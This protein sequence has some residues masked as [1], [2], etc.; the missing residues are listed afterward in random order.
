MRRLE[1]QNYNT[2]EYYNKVFTEHFEESGLDTTDLWRTQWLLGR[3]KGGRLLDI[4]CGISPLPLFASQKEGSE[5]F[6]LDFADEIISKFKGKSKVN[7][8]VGDMY[9]IPFEDKT[10]DYTVL[11]EVL[12]HSEFPEKLIEEASRVTKDNGIIAISCPNNETEEIHLYRQ[13][14]WGIKTSDI[15]KLVKVLKIETIGNNILCYAKPNRNT[16]V[17][18]LQKDSSELV[19]G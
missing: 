10:F 2:K 13:H 17:K 8:M 16:G 5:V 12:E 19:K 7:Y 9:E 14:I 1:T 6:A 15:R 11:G 3:F 4:G 18:T